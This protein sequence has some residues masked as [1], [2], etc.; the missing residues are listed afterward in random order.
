MGRALMARDVQA[1]SWC[2]GSWNSLS[3]YDQLY[4]CHIQKQALTSL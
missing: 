2:A 1:G 3:T 4:L